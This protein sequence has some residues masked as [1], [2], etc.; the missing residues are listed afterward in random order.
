MRDFID[1]AGYSVYRKNALLEANTP[2][3][4]EALTLVSHK[5]LILPSPVP[6]T[7]P[8]ALKEARSVDFRFAMWDINTD[9]NGVYIFDRQID[10]GTITGETLVK[11]RLANFDTK[12]HTL[13]NINFSKNDN[14][15]IYGVGVGQ[16]FAPSEWVEITLRTDS[17]G[18]AQID[19]DLSFVFDN[20]VI[21]IHILGVRAIVWSF[22]PSLAYSERKE[23][24]TDIFTAHNGAEKRRA[25]RSRALR[26]IS[27]KIT[28]DEV[29]KYRGV[30]NLLS[31]GQ[32]AYFFAPLWLSAVL[33]DSDA[34]NS[35][36]LIT[37]DTI[38]SEFKVGEYAIIW[39]DFDKWDFV[40]ILGLSRKEHTLTD[41]NPRTGRKEKNRKVYKSTFTLEKPAYAQKG[42][43]VMPLMRVTP[44][45]SV[46]GAFTTG[47]V[48]S[49]SVELKELL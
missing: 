46:S 34:L 3:A 21:T 30:F 25:M 49:Y 48:G 39:Q 35:T 4:G 13:Q 11:F 32:K 9:K 24:K 2:N 12:S 42:F 6:K 37:T 41:W 20:Q 43:L 5:E 17:N 40:K 36:T 16:I 31:Y 27:F 7:A 10:F 29:A 1:L 38:N 14:I 28:S 33:I 8:N 15:D 18:S 22:R 47:A 19:S 26:H 23:L 45:V 44:K